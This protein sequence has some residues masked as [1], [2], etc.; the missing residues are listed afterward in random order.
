MKTV[1]AEK[2]GPKAPPPEPVTLKGHALLGTWAYMG[3]YTREFLEDGRCILR[4]G[5]EVQWTKQ[6][7]KVTADSVTLSGGYT[8][9]LKGDTL[10]I[11]GKYQAKRKP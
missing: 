1:L 2:L 7:V 10:H 6:A 4:N 3:S 11:E 5:N 9:V 8:H